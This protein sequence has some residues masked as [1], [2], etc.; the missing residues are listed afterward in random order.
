MKIVILVVVI[1]II[2]GG[3]VSGEIQKALEPFKDLGD[4]LKQ[5]L[6]IAKKLKYYSLV[7]WILIVVVIV[8]AVILLKML[9]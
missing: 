2:V 6:E 4:A 3:L 9:L 7:K 8:V 5:E 1:F